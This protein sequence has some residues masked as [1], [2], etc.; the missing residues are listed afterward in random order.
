MKDSNA[1]K[2][3]LTGYVRFLNEHREKVRGEKPELPFHEITKIL[4]MMWSQ[5]PQDQKQVLVVNG[6]WRLRGI[7]RR[8]SLYNMMKGIFEHENPGPVAKN[9]I[10][11]PPTWNQISHPANVVQYSINQAAH[12]KATTESL[13]VNSVFI[14][15][16]MLV[17]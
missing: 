12:R 13:A 5:L 7:C 11:G 3:P 14:M 15:V 4:G 1:P 6:N 2:A 10:R 9:A 16:L 17:N 8:W